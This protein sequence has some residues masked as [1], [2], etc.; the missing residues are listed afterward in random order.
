MTTTYYSSSSLTIRAG[1]AAPES[2]LFSGGDML[3][4][5][6]SEELASVVVTVTVSVPGVAGRVDADGSFAG[7]VAPDAGGVVRFAVSAPLTG[8]GPGIT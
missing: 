6:G 5:A 2:L 7:S 3:L 4:V 8:S 1:S